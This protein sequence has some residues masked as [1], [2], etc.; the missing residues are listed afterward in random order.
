MAKRS[1]VSGLTEVFGTNVRL[2]RT[3]AKLTLEDLAEAVGTTAGYLS[4]VERAK[5]SPTLEAVDRIAKALKVTP[6]AL[7]DATLGRR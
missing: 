7:M 5:V 2:E 1:L 4:Q 3:R 6:V